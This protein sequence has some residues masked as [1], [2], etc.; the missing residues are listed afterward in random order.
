MG[1]EIS[2][3]R[4]PAA[5]CLFSQIFR[6]RESVFPV[7]GGSASPPSGQLAPNG[8]CRCDALLES[9]VHCHSP[10]AVKA[11]SAVPRSR[12]TKAFIMDL[13][14]LQPLHDRNC[15]TSCGTIVAI[16]WR[17]FVSPKNGLGLFFLLPCSR[18]S[19]FISSRE[20]G[21]YLLEV[22]HRRNLLADGSRQ[23]TGLLGR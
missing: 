19:V 21:N 11:R 6:I 5:I 12:R 2:Q 23:P 14:T 16:L 22:L 7:T 20:P 10:A 4:Y 18:R 17:Q 9:S 15:A 13:P 3:R 1:Q 8:G